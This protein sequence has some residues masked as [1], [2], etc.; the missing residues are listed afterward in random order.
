MERGDFYKFITNYSFCIL[1]IILTQTLAVWKCQLR[2]RAQLNQGEVQ[3]IADSSE[4]S[5]NLS[6]LAL[7]TFGTDASG[8]EVS[9]KLL[10][11]FFSFALVIKFFLV[12][13]YLR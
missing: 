12:F 9:E 1:S 5:R 13:T 11:D 3:M 2:T 4:N 7:K 6:E 10:C 8:I